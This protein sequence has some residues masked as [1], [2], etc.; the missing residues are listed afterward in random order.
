MRAYIQY[1]YTK[2]VHIKHIISLLQNINTA[3]NYL[4]III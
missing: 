4:R 3:H 1:Y 2:T